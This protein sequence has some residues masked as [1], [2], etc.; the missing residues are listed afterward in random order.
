[1]GRPFQ[2]KKIEGVKH[3][4]SLARLGGLKDILGVVHKKTEILRGTKILV[5]MEKNYFLSMLPL[6][7]GSPYSSG[8]LLL[9]GSRGTGYLSGNRAICRGT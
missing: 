7:E 2:K 8:L 6:V 1:M 9:E 4:G 5:G 3:L